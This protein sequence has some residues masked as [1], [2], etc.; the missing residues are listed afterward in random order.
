[1]IKWEVC[2]SD[3]LL[4]F[5]NSVS[6]S[7]IFIERPDNVA[8]LFIAI[9][10]CQTLPSVCQSDFSLILLPVTQATK[11]CNSDLLSYTIPTET[12]SFI[13]QILFT[14]FLFSYEGS[15][16]TLHKEWTGFE[17][18]PWAEL[19]HD[20]SSWKIYLCPMICQVEDVSW[21]N[22][23]AIQWTKNVNF[24]LEMQLILDYLMHF[25]IGIAWFRKHF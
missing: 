4:W 14:N 5:L 21:Y 7:N 23:N 9:K 12:P 11:L 17:V 15:L 22:G 24:T 20:S 25:I 18:K 16:Y 6:F 19:A 1:M 8:K 13:Q 3:E 2:H 10:Y